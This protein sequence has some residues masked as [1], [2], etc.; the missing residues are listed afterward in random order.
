MGEQKWLPVSF[1]TATLTG[2]QRLR[3]AFVGADSVA[4]VQCSIQRAGWG[5]RCT[6]GEVVALEPAPLPEEWSYAPGRDVPG[7]RKHTGVLARHKTTTGETLIPN[8]IDH[9]GQAPVERSLGGRN[10]TELGGS[11]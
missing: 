7:R 3:A 6:M 11:R 2:C 10:L 4:V 5:L 9:A 8:A 1:T